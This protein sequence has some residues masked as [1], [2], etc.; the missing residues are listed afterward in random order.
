MKSTSAEE[1]LQCSFCHKPQD[2][3]AKLISTPKKFPPAY[4]CDACVAVCNSILQQ[5]AVHKSSKTS[6]WFHHV[7]SWWT[8]GMI[9]VPFQADRKFTE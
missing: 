5:D 7:K 9:D 4:I 6:G 2:K 8:Y 1:T 3:V